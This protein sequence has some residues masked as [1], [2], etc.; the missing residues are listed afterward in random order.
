VKMTMIAVVRP[1]G[2]PFTKL[3]DGR[4]CSTSPILDVRRVSGNT[5]TGTTRRYHQ[6]P[7]DPTNPSVHDDD[8]D[9]DDDRAITASA[10]PLGYVVVALWVWFFGLRK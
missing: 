7:H 5:T 6:V 1:R 2:N 10:P 8:D 4:C 3:C 9:D